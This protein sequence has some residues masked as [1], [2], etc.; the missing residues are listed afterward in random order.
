M[1]GPQIIAAEPALSLRAIGKRFGNVVG[2]SGVDLDIPAGRFTCLV[3]P[4]G[5]GKTTLLRLI[6]GLERA[7]EGRIFCAGQDI[8]QEPAATRKMGLVFQSYALFPNLSVAKNIA[9][10]LPRSL[11]KTQTA[12]RVEALLDTVGLAGYGKRRPE[13]LSGGQQQRVAIARALAPEPSVLLLDEPLSALDAQLRGQVRSELRALQQRLGVT[14]VMVTHDRA[15]ALAIADHIA[16]MRHG[17][18]VQTGSPLDLYCR[19]ANRFVAGF[20]GGMNYLS[21]TVT[22]QGAVQLSSGHHLALPTE[23]H[24]TGGVVDIAIRP[25]DVALANGGEEQGLSLQVKIL[26]REFHGATVHLETLEPHSGTTIS[27]DLAQRLGRSF[28]EEAEIGVFLPASKLH[29]FAGG[30]H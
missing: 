28:G 13:E 10:G 11:G 27:L 6:C 24:A 17:R 19:P 2:L 23:G 5:C 9:Y 8:T 14:T 18:V 7:D 20:L 4:S 29:L 1:N 30:G 25:E 16:V 26:R 3:G 15:E 21:G 22:G 12:S